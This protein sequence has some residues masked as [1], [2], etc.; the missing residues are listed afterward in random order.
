ML[1]CK[2]CDRPIHPARIEAQPHTVTC[3]K[4]CTQENRARHNRASS[5]SQTERK[6]LARHAEGRARGA[7]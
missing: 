6:K 4:A 5:K 3:S 1:N 2:I 7:K